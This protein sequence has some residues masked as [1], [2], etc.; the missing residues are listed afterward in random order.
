MSM[1]SSPERADP[2]GPGNRVRPILRQHRSPIVW[3]FSAAIAVRILFIIIF[4][5]GPGIQVEYQHDG[6]AEH[7]AC[8]LLHEGRFTNPYVPHMHLPSSNRTPLHPLLLAALLWIAG[9]NQVV[10]Y[11]L[12]YIVYSIASSLAVI[13]VYGLG[14]ALFNRGVGVVAGVLCAFYVPGIYY[15]TNATCDATLVGASLII[16]SF[17]AIQCS[18]NPRP[19]WPISFG[20]LSGLA[21]LINPSVLS[22]AAGYLLIWLCGAKTSIIHRLGRAATVVLFTAL[23]VSPW[24][25]RNRVVFGEWVFL[26]SCFG[27]NLHMTNR[28]DGGVTVT[29]DQFIFSDPSEKARLSEVGEIRYDRECARAAVVWIQAN[30]MEF[31]RA[32]AR[33]YLA[34]WSKEVFYG[35]CPLIS[36][37]TIGLPFLA[38]VVGLAIALLDRKTVWPLVVPLL[39]YPIIYALTHVEARYRYPVDSFLLL[40]C[41]W[42]VCRLWGA[43]RPRFPVRGSHLSGATSEQR[44]GRPG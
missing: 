42:A 35:E 10:W 1:H 25:I 40:F 34:F 4:H 16:M 44:E 22:V 6:E 12:V 41:A 2:G 21:A 11:R 30:P 3:L 9:E 5:F 33:R 14:T 20:M 27:V 28:G 24:I 39:V 37:V 7:M 38:G 32:L 19:I 23:A 36:F 17:L 18:R 26:R 13:G 43:R 15:A 29:R 8:T 31:G